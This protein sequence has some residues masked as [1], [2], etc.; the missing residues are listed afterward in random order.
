[1]IA[2]KLEG[3]SL[4]QV[5]ILKCQSGAFKCAH[6]QGSHGY[7]IPRKVLKLEKYFSSTRKV[8]ELVKDLG[9]VLKLMKGPGKSWKNTL[10]TACGLREM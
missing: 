9:K 1:M 7:E 2:L 8:L 3:I 10:S 6:M 5:M 4:T